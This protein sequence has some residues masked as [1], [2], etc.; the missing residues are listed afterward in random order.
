MSGSLFSASA[1]IQL[2]TLVGHSDT[3]NSL[4]FS[5]DGTHLASGG[6]D[7]SV[8][9]WNTLKGQL[10]YR[11][12]FEDAVDCVL[13]H[14]VHPETIIAGLVSGYMFQVDGFSLLHH[15]KYDI[16]VGVRTTIYCLDY[17]VSTGCL[18]IGMGEEVHLT[19][20]VKRNN[21]DGDL[22]LPRPSEPERMNEGGDTRLRAISVKFYTDGTQ[23]VVSYMAHGVI[24]WD[25]SAPEPSQLWRIAMPKESPH[26][27]GSALSPDYRH[28][29]LYNAVDGVDLYVAGQGVKQEA[30]IKYLLD[31]PP[32]SK[33][34][35]QVQFIHA[36]Q[37]LVCGTT[38]GTVRLWETGSG[39][40]LQEL[41][42]GGKYSLNLC[43]CPFL[44]R[45]SYIAA[46]TVDKGQRTYI[47]VW[48]AKI[49]E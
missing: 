29:A 16:R 47:K 4:S 30:R 37:A 36:G 48:R 2:H 40:I 49:S 41:A 35:L 9:I 1:Y 42:H 20:E 5:K 8:I 21:Y 44:W 24:C 32:Q 28:I 38:T 33:H 13:W 23:L 15:H 25:I 18:A 11:V 12:M 45:H 27:G 17:D 46:G 6:D 19:R 3:I 22:V 43:Y 7:Q 31:K 34:Q 14:P 10:L 26:I 39:E